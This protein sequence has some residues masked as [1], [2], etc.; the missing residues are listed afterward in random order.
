[1]LS[2][3][4]SVPRIC[5]SC[6]LSISRRPAGNGAARLLKLS[7]PSFARQRRLASNSSN[8]ESET[9]ADAI[10]TGRRADAP[11]VKTKRRRRRR[12]GTSASIQQD[13]VG[14]NEDDPFT[15]QAIAAEEKTTYDWRSVPVESAEVFEQTIRSAAEPDEDFPADYQH[16][17]QSAHTY[18]ERA[19]SSQSRDRESKAVEEEVLEAQEPDS[20]SLQ[21]GVQHAHA[22]PA[23][24]TISPNPFRST[25]APT[26]FQHDFLR[27][28]HISIDAL[29]RRVD[30]LIIKNPNRLGNRGAKMAF[31]PEQF[32]SVGELDWRSILP[33]ED[34]SVDGAEEALQNIEELRPKDHTTLSR[35]EFE[36]IADRLTVDFTKDQLTMYYNIRKRLA[37]EEEDDA[38]DDT[39]TYGWLENQSVWKP[40]NA[41]EQ[42]RKTPKQQISRQ[43]MITQWRLQIQEEVE[44]PGHAS[45]VVKPEVFRLI[46]RKSSIQYP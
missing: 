31:S 2:R 45:I 41:Q 18:P 34:H 11:P 30:A 9:I 4:A 17:R 3:A 39:A 12:K 16:T 43:I 38:T 40:S 23:R 33:S 1:M 13:Q 25:E 20:G 28:Q 35:T 36:R 22:V 37:R 8:A 7:Q 42:E 21:E 27:Q 32:P 44:N 14:E 19:L 15:V 6:R 46:I 29:G 5:L 10:L 26:A 24:T